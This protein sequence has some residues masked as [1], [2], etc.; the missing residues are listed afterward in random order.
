MIIDARAGKRA[1]AATS[2]KDPAKSRI[3]AVTCDVVAA[4]DVPGVSAG[5][6]QGPG[7]TMKVRTLTI[8][9]HEGYPPADAIF[10]YSGF[11]Q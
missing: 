5:A 1:T 7:G 3:E 10:V 6:G 11:S 2:P 4:G 8:A 9:C